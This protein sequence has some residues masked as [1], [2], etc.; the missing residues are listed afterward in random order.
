L[1]PLEPREEPGLLAGKYRRFADAKRL[2][3]KIQK[4]QMPAFIR[5]EGNY[6]Q[7]WAGPFTTPQE[8]EQAGKTLRTALKI[9]PQPE[10]LEVPV[11]K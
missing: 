1:A 4:Q 2:L 8:A 7:V 9:S 5:K 10:T 6:Y 11:P 3:A